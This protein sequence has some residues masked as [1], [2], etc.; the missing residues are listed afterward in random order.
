MSVTKL[1]K[2]WKN[3]DTKSWTAA[4]TSVVLAF[5]LVANQLAQLAILLA[6]HQQ[7]LLLRPPCRKQKMLLQLQHQL[8]QLKRAKVLFSHG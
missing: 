3:A 1:K 2:L 8:L 7:R 6:T 4:K 5:L